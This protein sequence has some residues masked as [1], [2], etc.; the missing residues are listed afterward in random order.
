MAQ[1]FN[2]ILSQQNMFCK[3]SF[4]KNKAAP[5]SP[6]IKPALCFMQSYC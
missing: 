1:S 4:L 6:I 2:R 3:L 5:G